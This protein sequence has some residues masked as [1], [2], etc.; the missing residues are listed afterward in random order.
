MVASNRT[1]TTDRKPGF[2][3]LR[4]LEYYVGRVGTVSF[5]VVAPLITLGIAIYMTW[6][7]LVSWQDMVLLGVMY[8]FI[9]FGVTIGYHRYLTHAGFK[10]NRVVKYVLAILGTMGFQGGA[11]SWAANHRLHHAYSDEEGDVHSPH[12]S[13]NLFR[14]FIHA[15]IGWLLIN[16]RAD[17]KKWAKDLLQDEGIL[18][19]QRTAL[20]WCALSLVVPFAIGGW[21]GLL[22]GGL[23]RILLTQHVTF[24]VN[25]V[26]H[27]FGNRAF[28]TKDKS[29][30]NWL[31]GLLGMGEG[32]HNTHHASPRSARHG[33]RW[34]HFDTSWKVIRLLER[35]GLARDVYDLDPVGLPIALKKRAA[36]VKATIRRDLRVSKVVKSA[37]AAGS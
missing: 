18:F 8:L 15:H 36:S 27:I 7:W 2:V 31:V 16:Q 14:G 29:T 33:I 4:M 22:W 12:L 17:P 30:N 23:V 24:S 37:A 26:C 25:S 21:S 9:S 20:F 32:G 10:A 28:E 11:V 3:V 19:I 1:P 5:L 35:L 13:K 6:N 34:W